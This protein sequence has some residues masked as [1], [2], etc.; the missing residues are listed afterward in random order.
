MLV[1]NMS[2]VNIIYGAS[3]D[4]MEVDH[5]LTRVTSPLY[6]FIGDNIVSRGKIT[7]AMEI[8][9]APLMAHHFMEFLLVDYHFAYHG[10]IRR[11]SLKELWAITSIHHL[12]IK[13]PTE[14]FITKVNVTNKVLGNA[15][16]TPFENSN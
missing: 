8:G 11:P 6:G 1:D 15:I 7:L 12:C 16:L 13:F 2:S 3:F 5:E 10:I 9:V 4:K 14:N